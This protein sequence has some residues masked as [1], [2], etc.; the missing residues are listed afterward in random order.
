M[1]I[2]FVFDNYPRRMSSSEYFFLRL[3]KKLSDKNAEIILVFSNKPIPLFT[4]ALEKEGIR[5]KIVTMNFGMPYIRY[6]AS[7]LRLIWREKPDYV[8]GHFVPIYLPVNW[9]SLFT[10]TRFVY[11]HHGPYP[12]KMSFPKQVLLSFL[13]RLFDTGIRRVVFVSDYLLEKHKE[14]NHISRPNLTRI[15]N[16]VDVKRFSVNSLRSTKN[17]FNIPLN[18]RVISYIGHLHPIKGINYLVRAFAEIRKSENAY[19][20]IAGEGISRTDIENQAKRLRLEKYVRM[21]GNRND[22]EQLVSVSDVVVVPSICGEGLPYAVMEAMAGAKPVVATKMGGIPELIEDRKTGILVNPHNSQEI[23]DEVL[24]LLH[25]K[26]LAKKIGKK[27]QKKVAEQF[28]L[29]NAE[30]YR[31][32]YT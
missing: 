25:D 5:C 15:Y 27:A 1:K 32:L 18:A 3:F 2:M 7:L 23:A 22:V 6:S 14:Y 19:L 30:Q 9:A 20:L 31:A 10:R 26:G 11:H 28:S 24:K 13:A 29:D 16:G 4:E 21:L 17:D 12:E 8:H